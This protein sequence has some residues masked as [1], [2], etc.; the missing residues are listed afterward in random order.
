MV[1]SLQYGGVLREFVACDVFG[2]I[3]VR[4]SCIFVQCPV[5]M[6]LVVMYL[7]HVMVTG[8]LW[9]LCGCVRVRF[10]VLW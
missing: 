9:D 8:F 3:M 2:G 5:A 1:V 7:Q 10:E 4:N 6:R